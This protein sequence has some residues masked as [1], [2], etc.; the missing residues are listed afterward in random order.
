MYFRAALEA[1]QSSLFAVLMDSGKQLQTFD[2]QQ[3]KLDIRT[4]LWSLERCGED[5]D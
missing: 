5:S 1:V 3:K 4:W 2:R